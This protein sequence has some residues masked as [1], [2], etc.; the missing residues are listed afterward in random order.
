[1]SNEVIIPIPYARFEAFTDT[2]QYRGVLQGAAAQAAIRDFYVGE[3]IAW[4]QDPANVTGDWD[5]EAKINRELGIMD[6]GRHYALFHF[7][8]SKDALM[9]KMRWSDL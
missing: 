6:D 5:C 3:Q 8:K 4:C 2:H 7:E 9:F 1:M